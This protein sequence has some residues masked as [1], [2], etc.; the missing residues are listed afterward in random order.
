[1]MTAAD[2]TRRFKLNFWMTVCA[3][4]A[5]AVLIGLGTWQLDRLEWK[6]GLIAQ[7][8]AGIEA[9]PMPIAEIPT[10]WRSAEFRRIRLKGRFLHDREMLVVSKTFRGRPGY[11]VVTPLTLVDGA[12]VLINRGWIPLEL[13][14]AETRLQGQPA[15]VIALEGVLRGAGR[16]SP[17]T[18]DNDPAKGVWYYLDLAAMAGQA[19]L[20]GLRPYVIE[21]GPA[22]NPGGYP[23]GGQTRTALT[24]NHL[25]YAITWYALAVALLAVYIAFHLKRR[26]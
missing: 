24:N 11:H 16:P 18:P 22:A 25:Q 3:V 21:A 26:S 15:G 8:T 23:V 4:P 6:Q 20:A 2:P 14:E 10:D 1:M 17:W 12:I 7:R 9:P 19:K 5:M 13:K